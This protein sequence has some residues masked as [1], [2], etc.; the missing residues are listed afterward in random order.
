MSYKPGDILKDKYVIK[1]VLGQ[2]SMGE[3]YRAE[4]VT[5]HRQFAIKL[6][7]VHIAEK[8]DALVRFRR[9]ASAAAQLEHP[10][11][12]QVTDFDSTENGDFYL[13]M[14]FLK[15]ETLRD[16]LKRNGTIEIR[17]IF[18]IMDDLLCALEC[19][20]ASGIV[21]RDVKP[22]NIALI[23]QNDRDDYV[24]LIDF[25][26]AHADKPD[27]NNGTLT[28]A[29]QVY[30]T[31]QYL[32]PEQ[33]MGNHV[34]IR[35]DLYSCG[36]TLYE[37]I[38]GAP[39]FDAANYVLLL[40]KHLVLAPPHLTKKFE[41][42][43]ELDEVIQK[44][45]M[46][47]PE[48]RYATARE[49]RRALADIANRFDPTI[50]LYMSQNGSNSPNPSAL[51][52]SPTQ[53]NSLGTST[54]NEM[55][56]ESNPYLNSDELSLIKTLDGNVDSPN[57]PNNQKTL[58][59]QSRNKTGIIVVTLIGL[60]I[61]LIGLVLIDMYMNQKN[62]VNAPVPEQTA[63]NEPVEAVPPQDA[64]DNIKHE[65]DNSEHKAEPPSRVLPDIDVYD[66]E[67]ITELNPNGY[68]LSNDQ[69]REFAQKEC[70]LSE[71]DPLYQDESVRAAIE[72]CAN[73]EFEEAYQTFDK[74][75]NKYRENYRY[76]IMSMI[77]SYALNR[78]RDTIRDALQ[79]I[80][81]DSGAVCTPAVREIIYSLY[82]DDK[83]YVRL[84]TGI[85]NLFNQPGSVETLS[86]L[87]L[88]MPC[89][90]HQTRFDRFSDSIKV[91]SNYYEENFDEAWL[92]LAVS[93]WEKDKC[94]V[95]KKVD[96]IVF[97]ELE[98]V[99]QSSDNDVLNSARCTMCYPI[100]TDR[101]KESDTDK[102][103]L[104]YLF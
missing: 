95:K 72:K 34:D 47:R 83:T 36:C 23:N 6:L 63:S 73:G 75:K 88:M 39:P 74:Y 48:E 87:F 16:R 19:A 53:Q 69:I 30:G 70:Q 51:N 10:H 85:L 43:G 97:N 68:I 17:S 9:E 91:A 31:P 12:C 103:S 104:L 42:A 93:L 37:M 59:G 21:H 64:P 78:Y 18:H 38:E 46:K 92:A 26:I 86:W 57:H 84:R 90:E 5:I 77:T 100:W 55:S 32:S 102:Q 25:G 62:N 4:H 14:E 99:C 27:D 71:D 76:F 24:K 49:V 35:A 60:A 96:K 89:D 7:H 11:I 61:V 52:L 65:E 28:Q 67:I 82:D 81:L 98:K 54:H 50:N 79:L 58:T 15:G 101:Y 8:A 41:C 56:S 22:E 20:H 1:E 2:G 44:L 45:L 80:I 29:G 3:V 33:V 94:S 13:V 66:S 40:N